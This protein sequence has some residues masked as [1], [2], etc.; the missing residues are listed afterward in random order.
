MLHCKLDE[1]FLFG[2][3]HIVAPRMGIKGLWGPTNGY[4][5]CVT[6]TLSA[7]EV[8]RTLFV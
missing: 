5:N 4:Y 1:A 3:E 6:T 2:Q 8:T 7:Q